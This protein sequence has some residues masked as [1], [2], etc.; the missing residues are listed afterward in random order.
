MVHLQVE[1]S[2][3]GE[4]LYAPSFWDFRCYNCWRLHERIYL[5]VCI[6]NICI[7]IQLCNGWQKSSAVLFWLHCLLELHWK[8]L[9]EEGVCVWGFFG[10][11]GWIC[12]PRA[13][14]FT[15]SLSWFCHRFHISSK[16][17]SICWRHNM[18]PCV[19]AHKKTQTCTHV[20]T[21]ALTYQSARPRRTSATTKLL[22]DIWFSCVVSLTTEMH[23]RFC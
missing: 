20:P 9:I 8:G 22:S 19:H 2:Q 10:V 5:H 11:G 3:Q 14:S 21:H 7:L 1:R 15:F 12:L 17:K 13:R 6:F 23:H 4:L 18:L 16:G